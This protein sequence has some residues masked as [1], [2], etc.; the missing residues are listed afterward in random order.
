[1]KERGQRKM[2]SCQKHFSKVN[3]VQNDNNNNKIGV[4]Y[5][6]RA[7]PSASNLSGN[8]EGAMTLEASLIVPIFLIV[9]LMLTSAGEILM[10]H[11]QISQV[12]VR[13]Q[14]GLQ[15]MNIASGRRKN[16]E[17]TYQDLVP[18]QLFWQR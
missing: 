4:K 11:Q 12:L 3:P 2:F 14:R 8:E 5:F 13:Q 7:S 1:M 16:L 6:K 10:I 15:L 9:L 18:R 17:V